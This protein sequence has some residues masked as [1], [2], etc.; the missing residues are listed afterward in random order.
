MAMTEK[1]LRESMI[2]QLKEKNAETE[3]NLALVDEFVK[4]WKEN[5]ALHKDIKT[6]GTK[7][8]T[9]NSH[10]DKIIKT[11]ESL[12]DIQKNDAAMLKFYQAMKLHEPVMKGSANDYL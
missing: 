8:E 10:G 12:S 6:R 2:E 4:L 9:H 1:D 5:K 11:N 7:I 3:Y